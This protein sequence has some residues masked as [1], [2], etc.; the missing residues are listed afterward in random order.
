MRWQPKRPKERRRRQLL[1]AI[2]DA[3]NKVIKSNRL[4]D[5]EEARE[6]TK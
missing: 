6:K 3:P 2:A 1:I 4:N 5:D